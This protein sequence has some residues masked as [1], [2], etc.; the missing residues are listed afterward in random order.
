MLKKGRDILSL[1]FCAE[2]CPAWY[3][4]WFMEKNNKYK[5]I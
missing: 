4:E 1:L 2:I 3:R 5:E